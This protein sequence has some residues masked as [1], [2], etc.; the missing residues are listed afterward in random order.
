M[1]YAAEN[2]IKQNTIKSALRRS[3]LPYELVRETVYAPNR[4]GYRNKIAVHF[5]PDSRKFGYRREKSHEVI[6]FKGCLLCPSIMD[7]IVFWS[8]SHPEILDPLEPDSLQIRTSSDGITVSLY[9]ENHN[10]ACFE[11]FRSKLMNAFDDISDVLLFNGKNKAKKSYINDR[12]YGLDMSFTSEAFRQVNASAFEMLLDAVHEFA[13]EQSFHCGADLY[14]GSGIIGLTL[15]KRF[16]D[17]SF[18]GIEI[19]ADAILDAERN[20]LK[21]GIHNIRFFTGDASTFGKRLPKNERPQLIVVDP[22]RAGLSKEMRGDLL[23]LSPERI[24][25]VSCNPQTM[26]RDAAELCGAGYSLRE[27]VPVNM[28]PLTMH[29]E[30]VCLLS[31]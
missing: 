28:F 14:C 24:I 6:D 27:A 26:A 11:A 9:A 15:A 30:T 5:D 1:S 19:N 20:A 16:P 18:W 8:N 3:G 13:S 31:K 25:Y 23:K 22:P 29:C 10:P 2:L 17:A 12:I 21:N 4:E 7:E